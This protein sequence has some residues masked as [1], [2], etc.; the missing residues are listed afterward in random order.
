MDAQQ[1]AEQAS[2][3]QHLKAGL[4]QQQSAMHTLEQQLSAAQA[5]N[6]QLTSELRATEG[7]INTLV[8]QA[9]QLEAKLDELWMQTQHAQEQSDASNMEAAANTGVGAATAILNSI[10]L[11]ESTGIRQ[12]DH[13]L[14][15]QQSSALSKQLEKLKRKQSHLKVRA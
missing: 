15:K 8:A 1:R 9:P 7:S 6:E 4:K 5:Q 13:Q 10:H 11:A 2:Q 3:L 14:Y 12:Y